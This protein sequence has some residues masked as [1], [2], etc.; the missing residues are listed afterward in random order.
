M[1]ELKMLKAIKGIVMIGLGFIM[2]IKA[3]VEPDDTTYRCGLRGV[4]SSH[5]HLEP[6]DEIWEGFGRYIKT[7]GVN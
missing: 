3:L 5:G 7:E 6:W 4:T 1:E 2:P